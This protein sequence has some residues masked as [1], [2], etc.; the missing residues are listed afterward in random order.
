MEQILEGNSPTDFILKPVTIKN[1]LLLSPGRWNDIDYTELEIQKADLNTNWEDRKF[2]SLYLDHQDTRERGV[3]N[4]V[5]YVKNKRFDATTSSMYGD[6]EIW[7]PMIG[8][9]LSQAKAKFGISATLAGRENKRLN[10]MEDFHFESFSI[11]TDPACKPAM[12]NLSEKTV[13]M[14]QDSDVQVVTMENETNEVFTE[15]GAADRTST[16]ITY[17]DETGKKKHAYF[18]K[19]DKVH[20]GADAAEVF[21]IEHPENLSDGF[22]DKLKD[23]IKDETKAPGDYEKLK[24][25][26]DDEEIKNMIDSII[27]DEK[28]HKEILE[29]MKP[30]ELSNEGSMSEVHAL[31]PRKYEGEELGAKFERQ[32]AHIKESFR[33]AHPD[34]SEE[35]ITSFAYATAN[36]MKKEK[37]QSEVKENSVTINEMKGGLKIMP[38]IMENE[39]KVAELEAVSEVKT[40]LEAKE[41]PKPE[42]E[43]EDDAKDKAED[44]SED[45]SKDKSEKEDKDEELSNDAIL[46]QIKEMS[47]TELAEYTNFVKA[48][49][50]EHKAASAKEVTLAF[51]KSKEGNKELSAN[52]LLASIDSR[53]ASLKEL[54]SAKKLQE[55]EGKIQELSAKVK[56][57]DRKTLAYSGSSASDS[58]MGMLSFLQHRIN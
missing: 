10:R 43:K 39:T 27:A 38:E 2:T 12:I 29:D 17:K 14:V 47:A 46:N 16:W 5:G 33:K 4:W 22:D 35:K 45:E 51:K 1:V 11:V 50:S 32:V 56:T 49:L 19:Q 48:Y 13:N 30:T 36:K 53:I 37:E 55:M 34:W 25:L 8:A 24:A 40:E 44:K 15:L 58:N 42:A 52:D 28:K 20:Y 21:K 3:G 18:D 57:P 7:N 9:Y 31:E 6:L 41:E 23:M 26:T 54:D